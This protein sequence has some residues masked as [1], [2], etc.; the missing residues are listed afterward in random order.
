[1]SENAS[2]GRAKRSRASGNPPSSAKR[3]SP[4]TADGSSAISA[5]QRHAMI[6]EAAYLRAAERGF[7]GGDALADWLASEREVDALLSGPSSATES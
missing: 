5:E 7:S 6:A 3:R 4:R 2:P 1:M